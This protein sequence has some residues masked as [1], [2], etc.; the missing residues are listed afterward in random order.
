VKLV[1]AVTIVEADDRVALARLQAL[2]DRL[3]T[4]QADERFSCVE[5]TSF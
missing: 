5:H 4:S 2:V 3:L 1:E